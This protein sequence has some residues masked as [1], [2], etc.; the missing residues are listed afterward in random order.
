MTPGASA[1]LEGQRKETPQLSA[2]ARVATFPRWLWRHGEA[3]C[4]WALAFLY[5]IPVWSFRYLPTQDGPSHLANAQILKDYGKPGTSYDELFEVRYE[6]IPNWTSHVLLAGLMFIVPPLVAEKLLVTL[7]VLGFAGGFRYFLGSFGERCR[8]V[9]WLVFLFVYNRCLWMGFYNF[10]LSLVLVW[11]IWGYCIR[12]RGAI[13]FQQE[14]VLMLLFSLAYFTHLLGF[15]VALCGALGASVF[16]RPLKLTRPALVCLA[17]LPALL[18]TF[19]YLEHTGFFKSGGQLL[20][21]QPMSLLRGGT[22][23]LHLERQLNAMG[24][25]IFKHHA[26]STPFVTLLMFYGLAIAGF[27]IIQYFVEGSRKDGAPGWFFPCFLGVTLLALYVLVPDHLGTGN[28]VLPNGGFLKA[29]LALLPLLVGMACL[30]E[31]DVPPARYALRAM[32]VALVAANLVMILRTV[33]TG[34]RLI[35]PYVAGIEAVGRGQRIMGIP[36]YEGGD[37]VHP[38]QH[39][40][41]YYC[42]GMDNVNVDNYEAQTPHFPLKY[43]QG[44]R[45]GL[46]SADV[47][48]SWRNAHA[49]SP[50]Q[51]QEIFARGPL[52][53]YRKEARPPF[54]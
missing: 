14:V 34:N 38:L 42:L 32:A 4:F 19:D 18:W 46:N 51:W 13:G 31:P 11:L 53:I 7:Y 2:A 41:D 17:A 12:R 28:N 25:E 5:L 52:T 30:R 54:R 33:E 6:P 1:V 48:I 23:N 24:D 16:L 45:H 27:G 21:R 37:L 3:A 22:A 40:P 15:I 29:R 47:V 8:P 50:G 10:C 35:E 36:V 43:R 44:G 20:V 39:A 26:G 49:V 9:S